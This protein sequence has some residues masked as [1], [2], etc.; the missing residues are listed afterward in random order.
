MCPGGGGREYNIGL[1]C[2]LERKSSADAN[3]QAE[4]AA[5]FT[6]AKLQ[7][8][9]LVLSLRSAMILFYKLKNFATA[10]TFCRRLLE[11]NSP[12]KVRQLCSGGRKKIPIFV[13]LK[14]YDA[15]G[16]GDGEEGER[17]GRAEKEEGWEE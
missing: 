14:I 10:A 12:Q 6:H 8:G 2:E 13:E 3:R 11:M 4:L 1:R 7:P 15:A 9:H 17:G 16:T 5:Y